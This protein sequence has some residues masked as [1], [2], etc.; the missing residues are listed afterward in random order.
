MRCFLLSKRKSP[1]GP[2]ECYSNLKSTLPCTRFCTRKGK[3]NW[4]SQLWYVPIASM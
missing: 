2:Q 1:L 3:C 4:Y